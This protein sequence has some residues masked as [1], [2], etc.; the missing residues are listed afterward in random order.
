M[1]ITLNKDAISLAEAPI[2]KEYATDHAWM[3]DQC[4]INPTIMACL[5]KYYGKGQPILDTKMVGAPKLEV[6]KNHYCMTIWCECLVTYW[7]EGKT[8]FA[9]LS[10]D[11]EMAHNEMGVDCFMI[12]F[13]EVDSRCI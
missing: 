1:K 4:V 5:E 11:L 10:Y 13:D 3:A 9:K 12:V 7:R 8:H 2:A 6:N